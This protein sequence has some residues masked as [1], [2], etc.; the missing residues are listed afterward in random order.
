MRWVALSDSSPHHGTGVTSA[1]GTPD[2]AQVIRA[3]VVV[4][5]R[6]RDAEL[7][8][9]VE[10]HIR[11]DPLDRPRLT[12]RQFAHRYGPLRSD[13]GKVIAHAR[14]HGLRVAAISSPRHSVILSGTLER[15]ARAFRVEFA[16]YMLGGTHFIGHSTPVFVPAPLSGAVAAVLGFD[17]R[18]L[19]RP[20]AAA[21]RQAV[22]VHPDAVARAYGF[23]PVAS[24]IRNQTIAILL[25]YG[26]F[27]R[28][29]LVRFFRSLG[30]RV[31]VIRE[32]DV[33][34]RSN[35]PAPKA[36][37]RRF[38]DSVQGKSPLLDAAATGPVRGPGSSPWNVLWSVEAALDVELAGALAP[39]CDL[40]VCFIPDNPRGKFEGFAR[41]ITHPTR[42]AVIS[43]S[44]SA[45]EH[46]VPPMLLGALNRLF[47]FA[48]LRNIT[49]CCSSGDDGGASGERHRVHFP[50]SSPYVLA[51][52][53]SA[54]P[55]PA[56]VRHETVWNEQVGPQR[57]STSGGFSRAFPRPWWQRRHVRRKGAGRR[58]RAVPDVAAKADFKRGY[59][60]VVAGRD[61][62]LGGTSA[63]TPTWAA[64]VARL[65]DTLGVPVGFISPQLYSE[66]ARGALYA[67]TTGGNGTYRAT[68]GWDPCTGLGTPI[69]AALLD[70]LAPPR[71]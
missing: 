4:H 1:P 45:H 14:V 58:G 23:A 21:K 63:A 22:G 47:M 41:A 66:R 24:G 12:P 5:S 16:N 19:A 18:P 15:F 65:N 2:P 25:P 10:R 37:I 40:L 62:A 11:L 60:L 42:P 8:R 48:A 69:G 26:G 35:Q 44:W 39:Q 3:T 51:C 17:D 38:C 7:R 57:M 64:F 28:S 30:R 31:P 9:E 36:A 29:D 71:S 61:V 67:V 70:V 56:G 46:D 59:Q 34:G 49:V 68:R 54:F 20:Q 13:M 33:E 50:A 55:D 53:G 27:Y 43:C 32:L 52:G 6:C